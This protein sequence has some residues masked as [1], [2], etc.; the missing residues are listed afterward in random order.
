[1]SASRARVDAGRQRVF[2]TIVVLLG[3]FVVLAN[4]VGREMWLDEYHTWLVSGMALSELW[5]F[6]LG[7]VHPP[8]YFLLMNG[9]RR[10]F[11][12]D[13][14]ALRLPSLLAYIA[15]I[16]VFA[17]LLQR[18]RSTPLARASATC[19]FAFAP[20]LVVYGA[21]ARM[22]AISVLLACG[23]LW[24]WTTLMDRQH[25][26]GMAKHRL[27]VALS[28]LAVL[29][30][31]THYVSV[32]FLAGLGLAWALRCVSG[33]A[34]WR[35]LLLFAVLSGIGGGLW[36]PTVLSQ[37]ARKTDI[38]RHRTAAK[39][40]TAPA[41]P[42][43]EASTAP[44]APVIGVIPKTKQLV[45]NL[46]SIAGV[47]PA[48]RPLVFVLLLLP[49]VAIAVGVLLALGD[50]DEL[51]LSMLVTLTASPGFLFLNLTSRRYLL[52]FAPV[53]F[54]LAWRGL[55]ALHRRAP[56]VGYAGLL[57]SLVALAGCFRTVVRAPEQQP[58]ARIA[59]T[60][61]SDSAAVKPVVLVSNYGEIALRYHLQR[62]GMAPRIVAF[63]MN[64]DRWWASQTFKGWATVPVSRDSTDRWTQHLDVQEGWLIEVESFSQDPWRYFDRSLERDYVK[65]ELLEAELRDT[66]WRLFRLT[67]RPVVAPAD[68]LD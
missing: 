3:A 37:R 49:F 50:R 32:F 19:L 38:D 54:L 55:E 39:I 59:D 9:W 24:L 67:R 27:T 65:T 42:S 15:S 63:P 46:A 51:A 28:A 25:A 11:G 43:V 30:I 16:I 29:L 5:T 68:S 62:R 26:E 6:V 45:I 13:A 36:A 23:I 33:K 60:L 7:D 66:G 44:D 22:Y 35:P 52:F 53:M 47:F 48:E 34:S 17:S 61:A 10:L 56:T 14:M 12:D 58:I 2:L 40:A 21:E 41:S 18:S 20:A 31:L 57:A 1:M 8:V 4:A 64:I